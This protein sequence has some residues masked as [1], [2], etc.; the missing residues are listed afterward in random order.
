MK[1]TASPL[2]RADNAF[3]SQLIAISSFQ[4]YNS[5]K[6][7]TAQ[8]IYCFP[9][10][11]NCRCHWAR[12]FPYVSFCYGTHRTLTAE[13]CSLFLFFV[14]RP[15]PSKA[16]RSK[17]RE[18]KCSPGSW[19]WSDSLRDNNREL[20]GYFENTFCSCGAKKEKLKSIMN[21]KLWLKVNIF[22]STLKEPRV[23]DT[24]A[25]PR[26]VMCCWQRRR[27]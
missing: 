14:S 20:I 5:Q 16:S 2:P 27:K 25:F 15:W 23:I 12:L 6:R 8:G 17:G 3:L 19:G 7:D 22:L 4:S 10:L 24:R 1:V 11:T 21:R 26:I 13:Q 18:G 9:G